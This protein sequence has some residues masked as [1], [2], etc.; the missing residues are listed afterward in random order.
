MSQV[1][2]IGTSVDSTAVADLGEAKE[3]IAG[4]SKENREA[5]KSYAFH[6]NKMQGANEAG[7]K[8]QSEERS[9]YMDEELK[10]MSPEARKVASEYATK[11][12]SKATA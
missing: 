12:W 2:Q 5:I 3:I 11:R 7:D 8:A 9:D 6:Y 10:V 1:K 4:F